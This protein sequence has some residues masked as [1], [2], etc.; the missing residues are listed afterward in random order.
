MKEANDVGNFSVFNRKVLDA[1]LSI[2]ERIRY[3][4]GLRFYVGYKQ[5]A[6]EYRRDLRFAGKSK[7]GVFGLFNLAMD[8]L[9]SFSNI[10]IKICL[11]TGL[12]GILIFSLGFLYILFSK[13][14]GIAPFGWSSTV[15][16][17]YFLGS[18]QLVF[19][20]I[21]GEYIYRIFKENQNRPLYFVKEFIE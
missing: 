7:M 17:I 20:G 4:P 15:T 3:L 11:Y 9:F 5:V 12:A 14:A 10:P 6:L 18:V 16:S 1:M 21:I 13:I 8:A 19:L 2:P